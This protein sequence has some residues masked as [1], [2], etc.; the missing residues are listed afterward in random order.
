MN[1]RRLKYF[2]KS[3]EIGSLTQAAE[4]LYVAQPAL[5]QQLSVLEH[6]LKQTLLIRN[7]R[8]V[9]PTEAG[10]VLY[11]NAQLI[12][13][14]CEQAEQEVQNA[15]QHL[16]GSVA[17]GLSQCSMAEQLAIPLLRAV[18][19]AHPGITLNLNQN[20]GVRQSELV[21]SG[22]IDMALLGTSLYG[23]HIPHGIRF[24]PLVSE[25]LHLVS[26]TPLFSS[27]SVALAQLQA[28]ELILPNRN[29]FLRKT[30]DDAFDRLGAK[31]QVVAEISTQVTL[32]EAVLAGVGATILPASIATQMRLAHG[33]ADVPISQPAL[34]ANLAL[35][36]S[37]AHVLSIPARAVREIL[38]EVVQAHAQAMGLPAL[39]A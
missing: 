2:V 39:H 26:A 13:R 37:E 22:R 23:A 36:E 8:G 18:R 11:R 30:I 3:V 14:Q 6:E 31:A 16:T 12:L 28:L 35:C 19:A 5:S 27:A 21:M 25:A 32:I 7:K 34:E 4:I 10:K 9:Q 1:L 15:G 33:V 24:L 29:H 20:S 38:L 17:V